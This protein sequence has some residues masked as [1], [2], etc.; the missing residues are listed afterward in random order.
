MEKNDGDERV[1]KRRGKGRTKQNEIRRV[2]GISIGRR[3][4]EM[5][6][7]RRREEKGK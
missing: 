3:K 1:E 7:G 4:E 2:R 6:R 5:D